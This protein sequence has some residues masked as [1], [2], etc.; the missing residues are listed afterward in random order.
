VADWRLVAHGDG[1]DENLLKPWRCVLA[2]LE[3]RVCMRGVL[4]DAA[5]EWQAESL[6]LRS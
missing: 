4:F 1:R 2:A 6:R 3:E 5:P